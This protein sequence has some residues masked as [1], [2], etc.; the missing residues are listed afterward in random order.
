MVAKSGIIGDSAQ[1]RRQRALEA[2]GTA[3]MKP[4]ERKKMFTVSTTKRNEYWNHF[5]A[6]W[7]MEGVG[8][9]HGV[10]GKRLCKIKEY[11]MADDDFWDDVIMRHGG[12]DTYAEYLQKYYHDDYNHCL[13]NFWGMIYQTLVERN[14]IPP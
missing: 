6:R 1:P 10:T 4:Q 7:A 5:I 11:I 9:G 13:G 3:A 8:G 12:L 14:I 2:A